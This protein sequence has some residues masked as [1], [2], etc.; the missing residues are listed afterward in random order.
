MLPISRLA[1]ICAL[2]LAVTAA[3][4]TPVF[5]YR[6]VHT[7]PHDHTS[8]TQGLVYL[9]GYLYEGTGMEGHSVVRKVKLET[10]EVLLEARVESRYFGEG[11][12][13]LGREL[14]E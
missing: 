4:Q 7:Y 13:I 1:A 8:F 12:A 14:V 2:L 9:D 3:A 5:T 10:G 6:V 11:I